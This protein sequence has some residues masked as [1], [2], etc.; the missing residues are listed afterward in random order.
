[1]R[2]FPGFPS[3]PEYVAIPRVF[4]SDVL[5]QVEDLAELLVTLQLFRLLG[6]RRGYPRAVT[7]HALLEDP[8]L[9][10]GF[11]RLGRD[12]RAEG[13]RGLGAAVERGTLLL[14][15]APDG[16]EWVLLN[17]PQ[18]RRAAEAIRRGALALPG[19]PR[20]ALRRAQDTAP[21]AVAQPQP[22][23]FTLYEEN[24]GL[25]TPLMA[26][27]LQQAE[28]EYPAQWIQEAFQIASERNQRHWRYIEAILQR[29]KTEGKDD[30]KRG[31]HPQK[32]STY[33]EKYLSGPYGRLFSR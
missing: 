9:A 29:W 8:A 31:G 27:R 20:A 10:A 32:E 13:P 11:T 1:M 25:L 17:T 7:L 2:T 26:E 16:R 12:V 15:R 3:R 28:Q 21:L 19:E 23:I 6:A 4:F 33:Q 30:G 14:P 22:D 24:I 5:P 18:N